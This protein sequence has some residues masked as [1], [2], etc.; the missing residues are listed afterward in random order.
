MNMIYNEK[1]KNS[2]P[3]SIKQ[4]A[5][6]H[7]WHKTPI[8]Y[9]VVVVVI[10]FFLPF[11]AWSLLCTLFFSS[12]TQTQFCRYTHTLVH[13]LTHIIELYLYCH[14]EVIS[15]TQRELH[16]SDE[17]LPLKLSLWFSLLACEMSRWVVAVSQKSIDASGNVIC[18]LQRTRHLF[19]Q[20]CHKHFAKQQCVWG[21][22]L[23][24]NNKWYAW[25]TGNHFKSIMSVFIFV[26]MLQWLCVHLRATYASPNE[27]L[28]DCVL[29]W[30]KQ[31]TT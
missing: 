2:P 14:L 15:G 29:V 8:P 4:C 10:V 27:T 26:C 12:F 13:E 17:R 19:A 11:S 31:L 24:M 28:N 16:Q 5:W 21:T 18:I 20:M 22:C 1:K 25:A 9:T 30:R 7:R 6:E 3:K 23:E